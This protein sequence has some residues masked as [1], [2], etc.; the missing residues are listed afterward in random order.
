MDYKALYEISMSIGTSL[1]LEKMLKSFLST[2][3]DNL[4]SFGGSVYEY[5]KEGKAPLRKLSIPKN[6]HINPHYDDVL[7]KFTQD[8]SLS[9]IKVENLH[10]YRFYIVNYGFTLLIQDGEE[11]ESETFKYLPEIYI[12]LGI[13]IQSAML[14]RDLQKRVDKEVMKYRHKDVIMFQQARLTSLA[15]LIGNISHQWR[16]PLN[17]LSIIIQDI[18]EAYDFDDLDRKYID[19]FIEDAMVNIHS[20]SS[21]IDN[22]RRFFESNENDNTSFS[23]REVIEDAIKLIKD[24]FSSNDIQ[25]V[26]RRFDDFVIRGN[27]VNFSQALINI[28]NNAKDILCEK[29][30]IGATIWIEIDRAK[31]VII[32]EDN[33]GGVPESIMDKIFEPYFTTKHQS[34]GTG[35]G[36]YM[37]KITIERNLNGI[38]RVANTGKGAKFSIE[39]KSN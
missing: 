10:F 22:F 39:F 9:H 15:E 32:I 28:L 23:V 36:L 7:K 25:I 38:L 34:S 24:S 19:N 16:Q 30:I 6:V 21:T 37:S 29:W 8:K 27:K 3:I 4:H 35:I 12:K 5:D 31:K 18:R 11:I 13:A 14:N 33:G 17:N 20:M 26:F 2:I 1:N